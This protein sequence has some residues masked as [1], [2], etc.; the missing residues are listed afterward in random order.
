MN[1]PTEDLYVLSDGHEEYR[2]AWMTREA[3]L[4]ACQEAEDATDGNI[5]WFPKTTEVIQPIGE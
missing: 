5:T 3:Y 4:K 1:V 2:Y